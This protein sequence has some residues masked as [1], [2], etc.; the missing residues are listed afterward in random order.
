M[1]STTAAPWQSS[2]HLAAAAVASPRLFHAFHSPV[3]Q[4]MDQRLGAYLVGQ[5]ITMMTA[6]EVRRSHFP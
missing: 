6:I 1:G 4:N 5:F 3:L 2:A